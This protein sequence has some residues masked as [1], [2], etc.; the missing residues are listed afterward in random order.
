[1][2]FRAKMVRVRPF[3]KAREHRERLRLR[4]VQG[5]ADWENV[6]VQQPETKT[7]Q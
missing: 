3:W 1:M 7:S 4:Q 5:D 2:L 6:S